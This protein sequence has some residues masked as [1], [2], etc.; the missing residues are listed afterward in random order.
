MNLISAAAR[1]ALLTVHFGIQ[2]QLVHS[3]DASQPGLCALVSAGVRLC[4]ALGAAHGYAAP[5]RAK[6]NDHES[7]GRSGGWGG[8]VS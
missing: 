8:L 5:I 6:G 7:L 4:R 1:L 2:D 3:L